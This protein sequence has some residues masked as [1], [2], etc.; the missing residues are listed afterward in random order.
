MRNQGEV[1][2]YGH[3]KADLRHLV[4]LPPEQKD[5]DLPP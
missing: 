5:S 4:D 3:V 2:K 1:E